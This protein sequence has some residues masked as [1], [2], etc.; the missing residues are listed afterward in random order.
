M[1]SSP[2]GWRP[3]CS[4]PPAVAAQ[5]NRGRRQFRALNR[6]TTATKSSVGAAAPARLHV[7]QLQLIDVLPTCEVDQLG[8]VIEVGTSAAEAR[9]QLRMPLNV[10]DQSVERSGD[11]FTQVFESQ[12]TYN[13]WLDEPMERP[14]ITIRLVGA[15]ATR[16][17][18]R[19]DKTPVGTTKLVRGELL[20]RSFGPIEGIVEPGHHTVSLEFRGKPSDR[21]EPSSKISWIHLGQPMDGDLVPTVPTQRTLIADQNIGGVPKRSIVLRAP[22]IVR[23][24]LLLTGPAH[25]QVS[26]GF[27]GSGHGL[28]EI[29]LLEDGQP[30]VTLK[31]QKTQG[32]NGASW[33]ALDLDLSPYANRVVALEFR[34]LRA[35]QQGRVVFG[36]PQIAGILE[37]TVVPSRAKL[38]LL[39]VASGIARRKIPPWGP[40]GN[41]A[42]LDHLLGD[43]VV[44]QNYQASSTAVGAV[45]A[46]LL[47]GLNP[48]SHGV[49]DLTSRLPGSLITLQQ[50]VKQ[51]SGRTAM[52]TGVPSTFEPFGFATNWDE[53]QAISPV[54]DVPAAEPLSL[55]A[56]WLQRELDL[57]DATKRFVLVH[58]RGMHPPWDLTRDEVAALQPAEYG[59]P[60]DARRGG[61]T[62]ARIRH[63]SIRN[64]RRL[65]DAD[66][67]R[68]ESL[69]TSSFGDQAQALDQ[70]VN[71]LKRHNLW[72]SSLVILMGDVGA[73]EPPNI[74]FEPAGNLRGDQLAVPLIVKFPG[75]AF[76]GHSLERPVSTVDVTRTVYSALGLDAPE[77]VVADEL[78]GSRCR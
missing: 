9:R 23:C 57:D 34:G 77:Q 18:V 72:Q 13:L 75:N 76:A 8:P 70:L 2:A 78:I 1:A 17:N 11:P 58:I 52:F 15:A 41:L 21:S 37:P 4:P 27:W 16:V 40:T 64:Q 59:G 39:I 63:Q 55:A 50:S 67:V 14:R 30:P 35:S 45:M 24:P 61:I 22:S 62:L 53:Y 31:Q 71:V 66:W 26:V 44:F 43:A 19:L 54:K 73:G 42:P 48:L 28:G 3:S 12:L 69:M 7:G 6:S 49:Q 68:L 51:S 36:E 74:P 47:T 25:L 32:G 46:S 65:T 60:I 10:N 5:G 29:R 38:V 33:T 20:T 56:R